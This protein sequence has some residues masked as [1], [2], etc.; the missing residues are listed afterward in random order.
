MNYDH[1]L[2]QTINDHWDWNQSTCFLTVAITKLLSFWMS[3][4]PCH[5]FLSH[6]IIV[7]IKIKTELNQM[8]NSQVKLSDLDNGANIPKAHEVLETV[9]VQT[10]EPI[11]RTLGGPEITERSSGVWKMDD[12]HFKIKNRHYKIVRVLRF[13]HKCI[14]WSLSS[15][16]STRCH[17]VRHLTHWGSSNCVATLW[18]T[19]PFHSRWSG[20]SSRVHG[21][22]SLKACQG[23]NDTLNFNLGWHHARVIFE[24][25]LLLFTAF[26]F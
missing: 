22:S 19:S 7:I 21:R 16:T 18:R 11:Q 17:N 1:M 12:K 4:L 15:Y 8:Q 26:I 2:T 6:I 14:N 9:V 25:W 3:C 10:E 23:N 20:A 5:C 24:S 13:P